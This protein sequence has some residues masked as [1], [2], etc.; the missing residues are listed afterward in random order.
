MCVISPAGL[1]GFTDKPV[2]FKG[3]R[4]ISDD[5]IS[6]NTEV[7]FAED[8]S[9]ESDVQAKNSVAVPKNSSKILLV[10]SSEQNVSNSSQSG[11][12]GNKTSNEDNQPDSWTQNQQ[13]IL[14][15]ALKQYPKG[16]DQRWEKIA[17]HIPG[18]TKVT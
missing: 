1:T 4:S 12:Y 18:K 16:T 11:S 7:E 10:K 13:M 8:N 5:I 6:T 9:P 3:G 15:W 14:E 17:E 2:K